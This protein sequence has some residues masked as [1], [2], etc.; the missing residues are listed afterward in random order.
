MK[1]NLFGLGDLRKQKIELL[2]AIFIGSLL[3]ANVVAVKLIGARFV[4]SAG[5]IAY[6]LTFLITDA[7]G[8]VFGK[9]RAQRLVWMGFLAQIWFL[10]GIVIAQQ[11]RYPVFWDG[12]AAYARILGMVPRIVFASLVAYL[13]SQ[14]HDVWAFHFWKGVTKG[15]WLW[16][17]NNASTVVSQ[18]LDSVVFIHLAFAGTVPYSVVWSMIGVQYVTKV[19]IAAVDTPFVYLV[20][21]WL[22]GS[23]LKAPWSPTERLGAKQ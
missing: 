9:K 8:D 18:G 11:L 1:R 19:I 2:T 14:L 16:L 22:R 5:V 3:V 7:I 17:R 13:L 12:Q 21:R 20:V 4:Q 15:K 23:D 10:L 6:P